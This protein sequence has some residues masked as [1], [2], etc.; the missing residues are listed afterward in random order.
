MERLFRHVD[1]YAAWKAELDTQLGRYRDWLQ[2]N[3]LASPALDAALATCQSELQADGITLAFAGEFSRGKTE[4]INALFFADYG[5]RMLPSQAGR[6]TMCPTEIFFDAAADGPYLQLLPIDSRLDER[7][8]T[9]WRKAPEAWQRFALDDRHPDAM[10]A[11][12]AKVTETREVETA[13]AVQL[14]FDPEQLEQLDSDG[15]VSIPAWR[16][17]LISIDH[18]L[19]RQGLRI[20]DTP[21]LNALGAEPELTLSL[22]PHAQAVLFLIGADTGV[23]A[24]DLALWEQCVKPSLGD[25]PERLFAVMNKIDSLWDDLGGVAHV[26][27]SL[28]N[29][30]QAS[31]RQLALPAEHILP[32]SAK[33]ALLGKVRGDLELLARSQL[34]SLEQLLAERIVGARERLLQQRIVQQASG[35]LGASRTL[36]EQRLEAIRAQYAQLADEEFPGAG[37]E[38][39]TARTRQEYD[40]YHRRLLDLRTT[41]NMLAGQRKLLTDLVAPERL[42]AHLDTARREFRTSL[43][44]VGINQSIARFFRVVE[45]DLLA[46]DNEADRANKVL[47]AVYQRHNVENPLH[48]LEAPRLR[49]RP[50]VR[51][52]RQ[53]QLKTEEVQRQV[54]TLL[55]EQSALAR[56][57]FA[58][59]AQEVQAL[60]EGAH[61]QVLRWNDGALT[62]LVQHTREQ[63]Q[64]LETSML[65][66]KQLTQQNLNSQE[67]VRRLQV[68]E[69]VLHRQLSEVSDMLKQISRPAP[70]QRHD[71]VVAL[72]LARVG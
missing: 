11:L 68:H 64:L 32:L 43:T 28:E 49:I 14:G 66:L 70:S 67:Q 7:S 44:T 69:D 30:R 13:T 9:A 53:L 2:R 59:V 71:N 1:A 26:A 65:A 23:T 48:P 16:H 52:L 38:L 54:K 3:R 46:L 31:A 34:D 50:Y 39:Q 6:T 35:L 4:L 63:K 24:S 25:A 62:P 51:E 58:T 37:L 61:A 45:H 20:L 56:R 36:I 27:Q 15:L 42:D 60:Q 5:Q 18:P 72:P 41:Q 21:G 55:T 17:A 12:L 19:L 29:V 33:Q 22:L 8:L 47:G 10:A 40:L 57:F